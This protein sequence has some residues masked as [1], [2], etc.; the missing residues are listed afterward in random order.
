[1]GA[2]P[3]YC[4]GSSTLLGEIW[5]EVQDHTSSH[6]FV[7]T[8]P[9]LA[10][11]EQAELEYILEEVFQASTN[12]RVSAMKMGLNNG[13]FSLRTLKENME[14]PRNNDVVGA[15]QKPGESGVD[16]PQ[17]KSSD[18]QQLCINRCTSGKILNCH[19]TPNSNNSWG[20]ESQS[21]LKKTI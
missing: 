15:V 21:Y 5:D 13:L 19:E 7:S 20:V 12:T 11:I 14:C 16:A 1:M 8:P 3:G 9:S 10:R 6:A 17:Q 4:R 18:L 2:G